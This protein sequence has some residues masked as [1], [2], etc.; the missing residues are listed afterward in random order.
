MPAQSLRNFH[1]L[2]VPAFRAS[3]Y[4]KEFSLLC[5]VALE[6]L[7]LE[8]GRNAKQPELESCINILHNPYIL[9]L[10]QSGMHKATVLALL[11]FLVLLIPAAAQTS[12]QISLTGRL[13]DSGGDALSGTNNLT[14]Q[15]YD[16][17]SGGNLLYTEAHTVTVA[18]GVW[19]VQLGS[20]TPLNLPFNESYFLQLIVNGETASTR[21]P[22]SAAPYTRGIS[23]NTLA[24]KL[25]IGP[26]PF[27]FTEPLLIFKNTTSS[28]ITFGDTAATSGQPSAKMTFAGFGV[29]HAGI[30]WIPAATAAASKLIFSSGGESD[31]AL[32]TNLTTITGDGRV[33]IGTTSPTHLLT[34][35]GDI[36]TTGAIRTPANISLGLSAAGLGSNA[37]AI[38][39]SASVDAANPDSIAIG[40]SASATGDNATV[41][42]TSA[43]SPGFDAVAIGEAASALGGSSVALGAGASAASSSVVAIGPLAVGSDFEA[44]AI[45]QSATASSSDSIAIGSGSSSLGVAV[46]SSASA[47]G[48]SSIALGVLSRGGGTDAIAI[49]TSSNVTG[50]R[51]IAIGRTATAADSIAIGKFTNA[52]ASGSIVIGQG[53]SSASKLTNTIANSLIIGS[54]TTAHFFIDLAAGKVGIGTTNPGVKLQVTDAGDDASRTLLRL[55]R[56]S[57]SGFVGK[58]TSIDWHDGANPVAALGATFDGGKVNL[59]FHSQYNGGYK[60]TSDV[61]MSI[62]GDGKVG[63]GTTSPTQTLTVVGDLN[64]T[65]ASYFGAQSFINLDASGNVNVGKNLTVGGNNL[66]VNNGTGNVGIGTTSP[67]AKLTV[68]DGGFNLSIGDSLFG[69]AGPSIRGQ[70]STHIGTAAN[71]LHFYTAGNNE[72]MRIDSSGRVGINTTSPTSTLHVT[73]SFMAANASGVTG[74]L[75]DSEAQVG[76]GTGSPNE[77]L[78]IAFES[79]GG[80]IRFDR[81]NDYQWFMGIESDS[82]FFISRA[83]TSDS[84]KILNLDAA[85]GLVGIGTINPQNE[86]NVI[87]SV[88]ATSSVISG[89]SMTEAGRSVTSANTT[90]CEVSSTCTY[91]IPHFGISWLFIGDTNGDSDCAAMMVMAE[92]NAIISFTAIEDSTVTSGT[93][94]EDNGATDTF[95]TTCGGGITVQDDGDAVHD[96]QIQVVTGASHQAQVRLVQA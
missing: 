92:N 49:G 33:G 20:V 43:S 11:G 66:F 67:S 75:V 14:F 46:G 8:L 80:Q 36:N 53:T 27:A 87:G 60:N 29:R 51:G 85:S 12:Q 57:W 7:N 48:S 52:S 79:T 19:N 94:D 93:V 74:L 90:T 82:D 59:H 9:T 34:V 91:T 68:M 6:S 2:L 45:G 73:G 21:A 10:P 1:F 37:I 13:L 22:L 44:I 89:G 69:S 86:L 38:G 24:D 5:H 54:G 4:A 64:V 28:H 35:A 71:A 76:I 61:T 72:R 15:I 39:N 47:A 32:N 95:F 18:N 56:D 77:R 23:N 83:D 81:A 17:S 25:G 40:R 58:L 41:I 16:A 26:I 30:Y 96:D 31:P 84:N 70:T 55:H 3:Q 88:N 65:G 78:E 62:L 63:I 50:S 42:G